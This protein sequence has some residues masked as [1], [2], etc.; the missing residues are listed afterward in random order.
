MKKI[1]MT[2]CLLALCGCVAGDFAPN[3]NRLHEMNS[4]KEICEK[5]PERCIS[6]V[7]VR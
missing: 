3:R 4:D 1:V 2:I 6:G 5:Q 7:S